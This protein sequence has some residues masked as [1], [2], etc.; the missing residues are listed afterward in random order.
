MFRRDVARVFYY[1]YGIVAMEMQGI[2]Q[3]SVIIRQ[4]T[5]SHYTTATIAFR[6]DIQQFRILFEFEAHIFGN[7][8]IVLS[9]EELPRLQPLTLVVGHHES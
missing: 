8:L 7:H 2:C 6:T 3:A 5:K 9:T 4:P 1:C